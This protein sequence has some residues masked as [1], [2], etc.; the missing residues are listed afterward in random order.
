MLL[1]HSG[2]VYRFDC[3]STC[4]VGAVANRTLVLQ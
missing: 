2:L 1:S 3:T 4:I